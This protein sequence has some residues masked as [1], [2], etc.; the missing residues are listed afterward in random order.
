[1]DYIFKDYVEFFYS[2]RNEAKVSFDEMLSN[3]FKLF[4][5]SLYGKFGQKSDNWIITGQCDPK[6]F[7]IITTCTT[8]GTKKTLKCLGGTV[9]EHEAETEAYNAFCAIASHVTS[10]ARQMLANFI[11]IA[12]RENV[13]Y[14]DTDSLFTNKKACDILVAAGCVHPNDLGKLK[15]E[16]THKEMWL[17]GAKDYK[18]DKKVTLKGVGKADVI[19]CNIKTRQL[20]YHCIQWPKQSGLLRK[21]GYGKYANITVIKHLARI[22]KGGDIQKDGTVRPYILKED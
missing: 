2:R 19:T 1:M 4:L 6:L 14:C 22:Y 11:E 13:Y 8:D 7:Q 15:L 17:F 10:Y 5:N 21:G 16:S 20:E 9:F 12:G 3:M 18:L